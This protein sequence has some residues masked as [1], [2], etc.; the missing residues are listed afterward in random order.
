MKPRGSD[1]TVSKIHIY[2]SGTVAHNAWRALS[3]SAARSRPNCQETERTGVL[4][5]L[6]SNACFTIAHFLV[7]DSPCVKVIDSENIAIHSGGD[8]F[9]PWDLTLHYDLQQNSLIK[10]A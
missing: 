7:Q 4:L 3:L 10:M 1:P 5:S 2:V 6:W 8:C 9:L